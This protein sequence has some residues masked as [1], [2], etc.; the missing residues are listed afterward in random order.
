MKLFLLTLICTA[1]IMNG[2]AQVVALDLDLSKPAKNRSMNGEDLLR[3]MHE[4]FRKGVCKA[5]TF[6]QKNTHYRNDSITGHS[7]WH[8]AIEFPDKFR[9]DFGEKTAGNYVIFKADSAYSFKKNQL[10][11]RRYDS[12]TL[13][14]LLG[15]MYYRPIDEV[16][17]RLKN[18]N[19]LTTM[20]SSQTW[21]NRP[22]YVVGART[23]DTLSN[24]IWIDKETLQVV[25]II[26][27][28]NDTDTMDMRFESHVKMCKGFIENK[29]SFRRN[30]KLE[31]VEEYFDIQ[32]VGAFPVST[33]S[34]AQ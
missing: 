30:G 33:F 31:Q 8:E 29:V 32:S 28:M 27:K 3:Q 7:E 17:T 25:R 11:K 14:L 5:Y 18:E 20:L 34:I 10:V 6:S 4:K 13:L 16:I 21:E 23:E 9:I 1:C 19:Y 12:N 22:V 24:Q 26:E 2:Q 15:G